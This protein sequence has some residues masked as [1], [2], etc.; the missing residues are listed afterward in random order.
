MN[1]SSIRRNNAGE[2]VQATGTGR[3]TRRVLAI[4]AI[5]IV[6]I[7]LFLGTKVVSTEQAV[8]DGGSFDPAGYADE[9]WD[10]NVLPTILDR[11]TDLEIVSAAIAADRTAAVEQFGTAEGASAPV[12][13]VR[14]SGIAGVYVDGALP[15]TV[16]G[17]DPGLSVRVQLGPALTGTAV[18]DAPG[19]I[20]FPQF[21]NQIDYQNAGAALNNKVKELV[22]ADLE[23][24]TLQGKTVSVT[25]VFQLVNPDSYLLTPVLFEVT[26]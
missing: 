10:A 22:I 23:P 21:R 8:A 16:E 13:S 3:P 12:F 24:L 6:G 2:S 11:A 7:A 17:I 5:V 19:T 9:N 18:R 1:V 15:I 25:G 4:C 20:Q 26:E 14:L